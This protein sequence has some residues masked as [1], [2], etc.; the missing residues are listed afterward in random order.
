MPDLKQKLAHSIHAV[1]SFFDRVWLAYKWRYNRFFSLSILTYRGFG[2]RERVWF[3]G[4]VLDDKTPDRDHAS[5]SLFQNMSNTI[6]RIE[7]DD[8]PNAKVRLRFAGRETEVKTDDDGFYEVTLHARELDDSVAWH[9]VEVMLLEP[10]NHDGSQVGNTGRVV[11]PTQD[12][13][14]GIIS[15]LD[16]TVIRTGAQNKLQMARVVLMNSAATRTPFPGVAAF[17]RALELGPDEKGHN[18]IFYVSSSPWNLYDL[19][20]GFMEAHDV[21]VGPLFLKDFGFT[22]HHFMKSGH[23]EHK[24][25]H[26]ETLLQTYPDLPFVLIGDSGQKDAEIY[27]EVVREFPDRIKTIYIRD[28]EKRS[29]HAIVKNIAKKIYEEYKVEMILSKDTHIAAQHASEKGYIKKE[30]ITIIDQELK[31]EHQA[32]SELGQVFSREESP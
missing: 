7:S 3:K 11:V 32:P 9:E 25:I 13:E 26:I 29:R 28:V 19:F 6:R 10:R 4:R 21:P 2:T 1:E 23:E 24:Y 31:K 15:D 27:A 12:V 5:S 30:D 8:I 20:V 22:K 14:Y 18:P 16:D 17:Y